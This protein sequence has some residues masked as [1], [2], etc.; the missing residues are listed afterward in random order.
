MIED[1]PLRSQGFD[2]RRGRTVTVQSQVVNRVVFRDQKDE[3]R[4]IG[5]RGRLP[6]QCQHREQT[7]ECAFHHWIT[8]SVVDQVSTRTLVREPH[9]P[10]LTELSVSVAVTQNRG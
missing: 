10:I 2:L 7:T 4:T 8:V 9:M 6:A 3:I 1:Q 5:F